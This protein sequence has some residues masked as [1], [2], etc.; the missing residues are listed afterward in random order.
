MSGMQYT[1]I[2]FV[3]LCITIYI[4]SFIVVYNKNDVI[5]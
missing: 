1:H 2:L 5:I 4:V 3:Y